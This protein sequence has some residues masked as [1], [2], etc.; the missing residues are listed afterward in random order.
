M[1][2]SI[3]IRHSQANLHS[4]C[5]SMAS[6]GLCAPRHRSL[7]VCWGLLQ[8][9]SF[10]ERDRSVEARVMCQRCSASADGWCRNS[11]RATLSGTGS[12]SRGPEAAHQ[13]DAPN[14]HLSTATGYVSESL[15]ASFS[16]A[17][18]PASP[19]GCG[20]LPLQTG[21]ATVPETRPSWAGATTPAVCRG[22]DHCQGHEHT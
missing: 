12:R 16:R 4:C 6:T 5:P 8:Q 17:S 7:F 11:A 22:H 13:S 1:P 18:A 3:C 20:R 2:I 9:C 15:Q 10:N 21:S 19:G 14:V